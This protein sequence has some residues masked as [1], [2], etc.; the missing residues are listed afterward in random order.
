MAAALCDLFFG[1]FDLHLLTQSL[2][3]LRVRLSKVKSQT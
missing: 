1:S 3:H 2:I